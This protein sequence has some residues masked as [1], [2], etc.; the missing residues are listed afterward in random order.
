ML[1]SFSGCWLMHVE[2]WCS[3]EL[4]G[5]KSGL[6]LVSIISPLQHFIHDWLNF[7]SIKWI[8]DLKDFNLMMMFDGN[9]CVQ[10]CKGPQQ[11]EEICLGLFG[12]L[13]TETTQAQRVC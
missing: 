8:K 4:H 5:I 3:G 6:Q 13:L 2:L 10:V 12:L 9:V 7:R 1:N 11:H